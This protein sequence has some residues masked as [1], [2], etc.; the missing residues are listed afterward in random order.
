M[1]LICLQN[2]L[3]NLLN[4]TQGIVGQH[5]TL[6]ILNNVL[7]Q[8]Q[9]G[10]LKI[11]ATNLEMA[12]V[13]ETTA[14]VEKPGSLTVPAKILNNLISNLSDK[15]II[16]ETRANNI[17]IKSQNYQAIIKGLTAKDFPI[18]PKIEKQ[19]S[20]KV[21]AIILRSGLINVINSVAL[22]DT[23]P[24]IS[25]ILFDLTNKTLKLVSTDSFRLAERKIKIETK[26]TN[27]QDQIIV[28]AR[29][30]QEL[31]K[32]LA[33]TEKD[34][35]VVIGGSQ[36]LFSCANMQ[37]IS[38]LIEGR[39]PDYQ[40]IIPG[41]FETQ[42]DIDKKEFS[43]VVKV[44]SL[45]SSKINDLTLLVDPKKSQ[46]EISAQ[47]I[48]LGENKANLSA[49]TEGQSVKLVCNYRYLLEGLNNITASRVSIGLNGPAQPFV[50]RGSGQRNFLYLI[51]PLNP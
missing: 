24:E 51:M 36:V 32:I 9:K 17:I 3:K 34:V 19:H 46:I 15:K 10:S 43:E 35:E 30:I 42:V 40:E 6:P 37:L 41:N 25:G 50:L 31:I 22:T 23:R 14:K 26:Q 2:N 21:S 39:Y 29:T 28:P 4:L 12:L 49:E 8:A 48:D 20:F 45:F 38:R 13:I 44:T 1:Y 7:I 18:I 33:L 47:N 16:I 11:S 27:L 5:L